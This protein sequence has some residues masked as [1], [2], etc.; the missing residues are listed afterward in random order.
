MKTIHGILLALACLAPGGAYAWGDEGHK[1]VGRIAEHYLT[2]AAREQVQM[3]LAGD[4]SGLVPVTDM[5]HEA[6]WADKY[7]DS[8]RGSG[9]QR[10]TQTSQWHYVDI[11][12]DGP[13]LDAACYRHPAVPAGVPASAGEANDCI[14]D[15]IQEF[16]VELADPATPEEERRLALQFLL[17]FLG[18]LHQPLHAADDHD[19]GGNTKTVS[20]G[21][22]KP[23]KLHSRWDTEFVQRLGADDQVVAAQLI[24]R[25]TPEQIAQWTQGGPADWAQ[26]SYGI[27]RS[28]VYG[29]L[30]QPNAN[31]S[32]TLDE[33]YA[34]NASRIAAEQLSKAGVRLAGIL[35]WALG[36]KRQP[37]D[38]PAEGAK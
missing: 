20:S 27:A 19:K 9:K 16:S 34:D 5:A 15:K 13:D 8:D 6:T 12:L 33:A 1:I 37:K 26:E 25:I 24:A 4:Q 14:V 21:N 10:Y 22:A 3:L 18:D 35:N 32:Y 30:P 28:E 31:G 29:R 11:E 36:E 7:R 23:G 2:P 17:H 38:R